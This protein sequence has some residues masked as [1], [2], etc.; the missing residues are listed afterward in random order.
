MQLL[1]FSIAAA[2]LL[3]APAIAQVA[4]APCFE[5]SLG[6]NLNLLDDQV[7]PAQSLGFTFPG[8]G[9]PTTQV[10]VSSNGFVWMASSTDHRCCSADE[11]QFL[12]DPASIAAM[13]MD[14][15]PPGAAPVVEG[16][17][18]NAIPGTGTSPSRGVVTWYKVPEYGGVP[19]ETVQIQML[20]TGEIVIWHDVNNGIDP[21]TG[22]IALVGVTQGNNATANPINFM[23]LLGGPVNT[24]TNPTAYEMFDPLSPSTYDIGGR[25]FEFIPNGTGGY[26][27]FERPGCRQARTAKYGTG[28]P[29]NGTVYEAFVNNVDLAN[30]SVR[31]INI[32]TGYVAVPGGGFDNGYLNA[33]PGVMDDSIHQGLALGFTFPFAGT[34]ITTVDLSSNGYLW[35]ASNP[36]SSYFPVIDDFLTEDSRIAPFWRDLYAP[37]GGAIYWDTT[38]SFAMATWVGVPNFPLQIP[39]APGNTFQV[40]LYPSGD[41]EFSYGSLDPQNP[42]TS[43]ITVVGFTEGNNAAD[44]GSVDLSA[45]VPGLPVGVAGAVPLDLDA[46][47]GSSPQLNSV[48]TMAVTEV[49]AGAIFGFMALSFGQLPTGVDLGII[50]F[51]FGCMAYIDPTGSSILSF[52]AAPP[53]GN[54]ALGIPNNPGLMGLEIFAQAFVLPVLVPAPFPAI[55]SNGLKLTLGM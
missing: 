1:R 27:I 12:A 42:T 37:G 30:S 4:N 19:I 17:F 7:S 16:V 45:S 36:Y 15:Y 33:I 52:P 13:W 34:T 23:S 41:I 46:A 40:K 14:F 9:G 51:P 26:L 54:A 20:S 25:S 43:E 49:P 5:T 35:G 53:T 32:G 8:P 3:H 48:F 22:H 47:T 10:W 29:R 11:Q 18:F 2:I 6:T 28:C 24:G 44:P 38:P 21:N 39:P 31:F 50:G 55:V